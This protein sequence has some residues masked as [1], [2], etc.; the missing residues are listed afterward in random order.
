MK[1]LNNFCHCV[2]LW[3]RI[4]TFELMYFINCYTTWSF[5]SWLKQVM[6]TWVQPG[7]QGSLSIPCTFVHFSFILRVTR[8]TFGK[9][10]PIQFSDII[11]IWLFTF[12]KCP[13]QIFSCFLNIFLI[14]C[15]QSSVLLLLNSLF[16]LLLL[17]S[18]F[19]SAFP[20]SSL[21]DIFPILSSL[22]V[23]VHWSVVNRAGWLLWIILFTNAS[24]LKG[25]VETWC[26]PSICPIFI[27]LVLVSE[28]TG[29]IFVTDP[30]PGLDLKN[31]D[32][33]V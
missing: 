23:L 14:F 4:S 16:L 2:H 18:S 30:N 31:L 13:P 6:V 1:S 32:C 15:L 12:V 24:S 33:Q 25:T 21:V 28:L 27:T 9:C 26:D 22:F 7:Y 20:L 3:C 19:I 29:L 10:L 5:S 8:S 11:R 17:M